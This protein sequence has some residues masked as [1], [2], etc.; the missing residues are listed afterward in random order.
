MAEKLIKTKIALK[1][2]DFAYWTTGEGK[3]YIPL[4]GEVCF[5]TITPVG[6]AGDQ[7]NAATTAPTVLFKVGTYDGSTEATK[8]KFSELNWASALAAD[9]FDWAKLD[10]DTFKAKYLAGAELDVSYAN[11]NITYSHESK[12]GKTYTTSVPNDKSATSFNDTV[13]IKVPKL[14]VNQYGHITAAEDTEYTI[15]IPTPEA[16]SNTVTTLEEGTGIEIED[17][18]T[19]GNHNY[20]VSHQAKPTTG[21][22]VGVV[23][24]G[25]GRTYVTEVLID[26]LGH[27]AGVKTAT[28]KDQTIPDS[29]SITITDKT[30]TNDDD[31]AYVV[32]NLV[33]GG[34]LGHAI[35]AT[36]TPV[37]TKA[38]VDKKAAGAVDYL[39]TLAATTGLS[40][41]AKKGDFYRVT[42]E[43]KEG[44]TV[45]AFVGDLVIA[46]K[47]SPTQAIDGTNWTAIHC[48]DGDISNVSAGNGLTGG[49]ATGSVTLNVGAGNGITVTAD[50]VAA[51]AGN[52]ITVD[53][54]GIN[55]GA[56]PTTGTA[57]SATTGTGRTYVTEVLVDDYGHIAGIKTAAETVTDTNTWRG[58]NV[59]AGTE[60]NKASVALKG[61]AIS[62]GAVSF[63]AGVGLKWIATANSNDATV[64]ID[65]TVTFILDCN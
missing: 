2:N 33:E 64:D 61:T 46:E 4:R 10:W 9:V 52:H 31:T 18:K 5:C 34:T 37:A 51:K 43:I 42:T 63:K 48:G 49:G 13:T 7:N 21:T 29:P 40:T 22:A 14:T 59:F 45:L 26:D 47:D 56:K 11:G 39:G 60:G 32:T 28:E 17:T 58:I 8:K 65:D 3:D 15:S 57:Q 62:T 35:T 1:Q 23:T 6:T 30:N 38:Y 36:Y 44:S 54:T 41:T 55:H 53:A 16:A 25:S 12:L 50:A 27:I 19:D 20:V 24:G